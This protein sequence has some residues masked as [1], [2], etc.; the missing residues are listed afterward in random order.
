MPREAGILLP[1]TSLPG[2]Y[3]IGCFSRHAYAFVDWLQG[4]GQT[5]WQIL[6][7]GP[8]GYGDSPYQSFSTFAGNPYLIDLEALIEEGVLSRGECDGAAFGEDPTDIDYA[9]LYRHRYPLLRN[10]FHR[11]RHRD[12]PD[13]L[14]FIKISRWWL[15]D[16]A[17][18]MALKEKYNGAPW[19]SWPE[20]LRLRREPALEEARQDL[21]DEIGFQQYLQYQFFRQWT[22]LRDYAHSRGIRII[23]DMPIYVAADSAEVWTHPDLFQLDTDGRPVSVAGVPPDAFSD[24]GQLWGNPLYRWEQH[25]KTG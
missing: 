12:T 23:G 21:R 15:D 2:P 6:P 19:N 18:F 25:R 1:V 17:L 22:A 24:S 16:Y 4:A 13:Y 3:G 11:S 20:E 7:L 8:T 9:S 10:A 14:E 5:C